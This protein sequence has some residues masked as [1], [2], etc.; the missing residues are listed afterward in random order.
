MKRSKRPT[1]AKK[2]D[3]KNSQKNSSSEND[4]SPLTFGRAPSLKPDAR[5]KIP[6]YFTKEYQKILKEK[7]AYGK[8]MGE[9]HIGA[10]PSN[11]LFTST[12][13]WFK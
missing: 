11:G 2:P 6:G 8:Q 10:A 3:E 7:D 13:A 9:V 12:L 1:S 4:I 5:E